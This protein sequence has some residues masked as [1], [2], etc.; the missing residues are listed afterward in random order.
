MAQAIGML[1]RTILAAG[2]AAALSV[3]L[4][5]AQAVLPTSYAGP[6]RGYEPPSGW[7]FSGLGVDLEP[8][9]DGTNSAAKLDTTGDFIAIDFDGAAGSVSFWVK[10]LTFISGGVFRV[11]Q[12]IDGSA[13]T[14]LATYTNLPT[15]ATFQ[16]KFPDSTARHLRFLYAERITGN[17]GLDGISVAPFV[18]P[19]IASIQIAGTEATLS[20]SEFVSGRTYRLEYADVL[21]NVPTV[22]TPAGEQTGGTAPLAF[23]AAVPTNGSKRYYRVLDVAP[24]P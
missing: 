8:G 4:A 12:S 18:W 16:T 21:T 2:C 5:F 23:P 7:T 15:N 20:V 10:G 24:S 9:Y 14:A 17:V 19:A 1:T 11:D 22:W 6:W 3:R 13:W